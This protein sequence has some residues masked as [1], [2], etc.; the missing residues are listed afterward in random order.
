MVLEM[1]PSSEIIGNVLN[2]SMG[3]RMKVWKCSQHHAHLVLGTVGN[4]KY[5][6]ESPDEDSLSRHHLVC[7]RCPRFPPPGQS[8]ASDGVHPGVVN[9]DTALPTQ[10]EAVGC[11]GGC[12]VG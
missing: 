10:V 5:G 6:S 7:A 2:V 4:G 9:L 11:D 3:R 12:H 8:F 1:W